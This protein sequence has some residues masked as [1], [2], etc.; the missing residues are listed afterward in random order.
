M[1]YEWI[2]Q[3]GALREG[4]DDEAFAESAAL[5]VLLPPERA[6]PDEPITDLLTRW[7]D[8]KV[9]ALTTESIARENN[10]IPISTDGETIFFAAADPTDISVADKLRFVLAKDVRLLPAPRQ[11]IQRAIDQYYD[12]RETES[13]YTMIC[14]FTETAIDF[15]DDEQPIDVVFDF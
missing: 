9:I 8:P 6:Q 11:D 14:E 15:D 10:V 3:A 13:V 4:Q 12:G 7:I 2:S 5:S 1:K